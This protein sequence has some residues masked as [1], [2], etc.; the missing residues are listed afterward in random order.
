MN[1]L[2]KMAIV[3]FS[4]YYSV[5]YGYYVITVGKGIITRKPLNKFITIVSTH[6]RRSHVNILSCCYL[7][8]V[9]VCSKFINLS[10]KYIFLN[11]SAMFK[12]KFFCLKFKR[13][14]VLSISVTYQEQKGTVGHSISKYK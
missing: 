6:L 2:S 5:A 12:N 7:T 4:S 10:P 14:F 3:V 13:N 9:I 11:L 1:F 8:P